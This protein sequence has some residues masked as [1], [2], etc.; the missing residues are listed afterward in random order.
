MTYVTVNLGIQIEHL[1]PLP[2]I[3]DLNIKSEFA[4]QCFTPATVRD[5]T[6]ESTHIGDVFINGK[7]ATT[8]EKHEREDIEALDK[9]RKSLEIESDI[10]YTIYTIGE[11]R[12]RRLESE[13]ARCREA[14]ALAKSSLLETP[15][16]AE[17][18][19]FGPAYAGCVARQAAAIKAI[20]KALKPI[21][22]EDLIQRSKK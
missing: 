9:F 20:D 17:Q 8:I 21:S 1:H 16:D 6:I 13:L 22:I 10:P 14:L 2:G 3:V 19:D 15:I 7:L 5:V 4:Q 18:F 12:V 11:L